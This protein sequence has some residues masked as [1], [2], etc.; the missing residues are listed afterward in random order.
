MEAGAGGYSEHGA[1]GAV[2]A[3]DGVSD[4]DG[5]AGA[6]GEAGEI[7]RRVEEVEAALDG[8]GEEVVPV[9]VAV[10][11][12]AGGGVLQELLEGGAVFVPCVEVEDARQPHVVEFEVVAGVGVVADLGCEEHGPDLVIGGEGEGGGGGVGGDVAI[13][14]AQNVRGLEEAGVFVG[15]R[16]VIECIGEA[17]G[18]EEIELGVD[19]HLDAQHVGGG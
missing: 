7:A 11:E 8:D 4:I 2:T 3:E 17:L 19:V 6:V 14:V 13:P 15:E 9:G 12:P 16:A 18:Y 10:G 5:V 1:D